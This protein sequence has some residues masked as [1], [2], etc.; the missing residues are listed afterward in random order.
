V[1]IALSNLDLLYCG[2]FSNRLVSLASTALTSP[3]SLDD[4]TVLVC[5]L[6]RLPAARNKQNFAKPSV[7]SDGFLPAFA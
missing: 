1:L 4:P 7:Y 2:S 5:A 6:P 3:A